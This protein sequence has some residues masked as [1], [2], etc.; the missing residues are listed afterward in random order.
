M[1][2]LANGWPLLLPELLLLAGALLIPFL[3]VQAGSRLRS[4]VT[5]TILALTFATIVWMLVDDPYGFFELY[6]DLAKDPVLYGVLEVTSFALFFKLVFAAVALLTC[7]VSSDYLAERKQGAEYYALLLTATLGMLIVA[8]AR[9]LITLFVGL[10]TAALSS[11]TLAGYRRR[12]AGPAEAVTKF[13]IIGALSAALTLYGISLVYAI[14]GTVDI[15]ALA[16]AINDADVGRAPLLLAVAFLVAGFGFKVT[17]VP[18]HMWAPDVYQGAPDPVSGLLSGGSK[19]MG[20]AAF[21]K[22]FFVALVAVKFEWSILVGIL[23]VLTMTVGNLAALQQ[24][25]LKRLLAWSSIAQA[26]YILIAIPVGTEFALTGG[27]FHVLTHSLMK[28]GA[29]A[30]VAILAARGIGDSIDGYRGLHRR[31]PLMAATLALLMLSM[32]GIPP[33]AGFASKFVL[34]GG[35]I[36][37]GV[38]DD[39][40]WF[41]FLAIAG[42]V[43]SAL[44]LF[45]YARVLRVVYLDEP[46]ELP[47][48]MRLPLPA[49]ATMAVVLLLVVVIGVWPQPF[50]ELSRTAAESLLTAVP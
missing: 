48:R 42:I 33:L 21:F 4:Q 10:E 49:T 9:D 11:Y 32:A 35:A 24:T 20:F 14:A 8:G 17:T 5:T 7:V 12:E 2:D 47:T 22:V 50:I 6:P 26:G 41:L 30:L 34:F 25:S 31:E 36:Q 39:N 40:N 43:N 37:A 27:L 19:K 3:P 18:F 28:G 1:A 29:F 13:F 44:S 23:A 45:Y 15:Y 38:A 46:E 16:D